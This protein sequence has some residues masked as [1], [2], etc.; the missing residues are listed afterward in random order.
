MRGL[1]PPFR[2]CPRRPRPA[3]RS[4]TSRMT[5]SCGASTTTPVRPSSTART[6]SKGVGGGGRYDGLVAALGGPERL[7][8]R[9]SAPASSGSCSRVTPRASSCAGDLRLSRAL[10]AFVVDATGE[11]DRARAHPR[12]AGC[13][14]GRRPGVRR[15]FDEGAAEGSRPFGRES[16]LHRG[17]GG[18]RRRA[19][20][21]SGCCA[22]RDAHVQEKVARDALAAR[23]GQ[24]TRS[25]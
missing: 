21:P 10:D 16:G 12:A 8:S 18:A 1:P 4:A 6:S 22:A 14:P 9:V 25:P 17:C 23:L 13:R 24:I 7:R 19:L 2:R 11:G 3:R 15:A 20:S 5:T